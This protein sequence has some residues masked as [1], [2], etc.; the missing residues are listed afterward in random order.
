MEMLE[1]WNDVEICTQG[2]FYR[3][4]AVKAGNVI[5]H[6]VRFL[7]VM[8]MGLKD[9]LNLMKKNFIEYLI[10]GSLLPKFIANWAIS[11]CFEIV[12]NHEI[13]SVQ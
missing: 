1:A 5:S 9:T 12:T 3:K 8:K 10:V 6:F 11:H 13:G 2:A 4:N 7:M